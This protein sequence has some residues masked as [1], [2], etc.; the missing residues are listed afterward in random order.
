VSFGSRETGNAPQLVITATSPPPEPSPILADTYVRGGQYSGINYGASAEIVA[1][2]G[3]PVYSR[4]TYMKLDISGVE[5]GSDVRLRLFGRLSD[6]RAANV[7]S[8]IYQ[9][10]S[11]SWSETG[12][13]WNTRPP[14]GT[15]TWG[16][17][18]VSGTT[19][20]WYDVDLTEHVQAERAAGQTV[21]G[22][23]L[24]NTA[25]TLPYVSFSSRETANAPQLIVTTSTASAETERVLADE[26]ARA[27]QPADPNDSEA[28]E[29]IGTEG[30]RRYAAFNLDTVDW[31]SASSRTHAG[32][33]QRL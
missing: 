6:T 31:R 10:S 5:P 33:R 26:A 11:T 29:M 7:T 24:K 27:G 8:T 3:E 25:E 19:A 17:V 9:L 13:T 20:A 23:V 28:A 15:T 22:I 32:D 30:H 18:A 2:L 16:T 1:K 21:I 12:V 4:E 14:A